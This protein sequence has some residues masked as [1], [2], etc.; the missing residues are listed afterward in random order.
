MNKQTFIKV[1]TV[2]FT[3]IGIVHLYRA[4]NALP[5]VFNTW[6]V[7]VELSWVAGVVALLL[8]YSGYRH[9]SK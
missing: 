7:P 6:M 8:A 5:V 2:I 1:V 9:W 4:L 3:I